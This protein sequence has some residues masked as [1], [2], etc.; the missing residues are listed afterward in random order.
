MPSVKVPLGHLLELLPQLAPRYYS[1]SSSPLLHPTRLHITCVIT[2]FITGTGRHHLGVASNHLLT[3]MP[4]G[5]VLFVLY[6]SHFY[7]LTGEGKSKIPI[8]VRKSGF[9]LPK[10][11]A[12]PMIMVGPGTGLAPF[13]GFIQELYGRFP[14]PEGVQRGRD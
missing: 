4:D 13:R 2:T 14:S 12:T 3:L 10:D 11:P 1:I 8:F 7:G 6:P 5:I 9:R